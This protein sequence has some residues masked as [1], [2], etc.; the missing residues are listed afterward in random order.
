MVWE[1]IPE[2]DGTQIIITHIDLQLQV[3]CDENCREGWTEHINESLLNFIN[4][5]KGAPQ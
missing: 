1:L 2:G 3:E 4:T 5:G